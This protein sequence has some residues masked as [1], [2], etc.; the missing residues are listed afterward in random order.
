MAECV[1]EKGDPGWRRANSHP[2]RNVVEGAVTAEQLISSEA[3]DRGF[4][5]ELPRGL[6]DEPG[7]DAV[8]GRL[9]HGGE[10]LRQVG[11]EFRFRNDAGRMRASILG[12]DLLGE[13][14][15]VLV[16]AA[17]VVISERD[18]MNVALPD[19]AHETEQCARIDSCR[20][21]NPDRHVG[22]EVMA[23]AVAERGRDLVLR[24]AR[25]LAPSSRR[26][27]NL[28]NR[29]IAP[30]RAQSAAINP[31]RRARGKRADVLI[32]SVRLGHAAEEQ[33]PSPSG[34][35]GIERY[36]SAGDQGFDLR[37]EAQASIRHPHSRAA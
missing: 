22:D 14:R 1:A 35:L 4:E 12:S 27:I 15:L 8:D 18:G 24:V 16:A 33:K 28:R 30:R 23:D 26:R 13:R 21:K 32:G 36:P 6:A 10:N 2:A 31:Q 34:R 9:V 25:R 29:E 17:I 5:A 7:V 20:E 11:A 3:R 19:V 37:G